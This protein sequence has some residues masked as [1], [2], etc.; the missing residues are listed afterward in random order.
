MIALGTK[1]GPQTGAAQQQGII[2]KL[3]SQA[4]NIF[5]GGSILAGGLAGGI[6]GA[7]VGLAQNAAQVFRDAF[8]VRMKALAETRRFQAYF[9]PLTP[10]ATQ[11]ADK[12]SEATGYCEREIGA[13][14]GQIFNMARGLGMSEGEAAR[15]TKQFSQLALDFAAFQGLSPEETFQVLQGAIAGHTRAL[16]Q[17]GI[18][19]TQQEKDSLEALKKTGD[20]AAYTTRM[21]D[22]LSAKMG[23]MKGAAGKEGTGKEMRE[24]KRDLDELKVSLGAVGEFFVK[25]AIGWKYIIEASVKLSP[26]TL[27]AKAFKDWWGAEGKN[28][29]GVTEDEAAAN[30]AKW[31]LNARTVAQEQLRADAELA[32]EEKRKAQVAYL[33]GL[34]EEGRKEEG[35]AALIA[36]ARAKIKALDAAELEGKIKKGDYDQ[37]LHD[38]LRK[39][40]QLEDQRIEKAKRLAE[41]REREKQHLVESYGMM[42]AMERAQAREVLKRVQAG[43]V[44]AFLGLGEKGRNLL[45]ELD[46]E[47]AKRLARE[48][49]EREGMTNIV[50]AG[51]R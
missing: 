38:K 10:L 2:N 36:E 29:G 14:M 35:N 26:I 20:E 49:T 7:M 17:Y 13:L 45:K 48:V 37:V 1:L 21:I 33:Q 9:G 6:A 46:P 12:L 28:K 8:D 47:T 22:I 4:A 23:A 3:A 18:I 30:R 42:S 44:E 19:L 27:A 31:D 39:I 51:K 16:T 24:Y 5:P 25:A 41:E 32:A 50:G 43:G 11:W 15:L 40:L 34:D